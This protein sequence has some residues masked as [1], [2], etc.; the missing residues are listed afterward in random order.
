MLLPI[1]IGLVLP[2]AIMGGVLM[3]DRLREHRGR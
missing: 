3:Q 2:V 1:L